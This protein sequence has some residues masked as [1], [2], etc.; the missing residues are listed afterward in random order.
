MFSCRGGKL[1]TIFCMMAMQKLKKRIENIEDAEQRDRKAREQT[2]AIHEIIDQMNAYASE[3]E[4]VW[5][6]S[7]FPREARR[8][9]GHAMSWNDHGI[10][11]DTISVEKK[12]LGRLF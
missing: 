11:H 3:A 8:K 12:G 5:G 9:S 1:Q 6:S 7:L 2:R 10:Q 4:Q